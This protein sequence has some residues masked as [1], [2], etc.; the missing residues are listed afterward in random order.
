MIGGGVYS[1]SV[2]AA[3]RIAPAAAVFAA[4]G[5][6][7]IVNGGYFPSSWGWPTLAFLVVVG[8]FAIVADHVRLGRLD[9]VLLV[10]LAAF[11]AWTALSALWASGAELPIQAGELVLV[12]LL[13]VV[14]FL[15][16]GNVSLPLGVLCAVT[17]VAAYALATRLVPDHVGTYK[18][19]VNGYLL[20]VPVGYQN[21]L[22]MLCSL[23]ALVALGLA[24]HAA[25]TDVRIAAA[26]SLVILL[27][28]LYFTFSR[29]AAGA[30]LLGIGVAFAL[31][32]RR[33]R[34]SV[35]L[36]AVLPLPL[37]GAWIGSRS[38]AL[39]HAGASRTAAAHDGHRL[40]LALVV[41]ALLQAGVVVALGAA[42][43][44]IAV[45]PRLRRAYVAALALAAAAIVAA[46]LVRI[47]NPVTFV[48]H[49]TDAFKTDAPTAG[50]NLNHRLVTL[51]SHTRTDYWAAAWHEVRDHPLLGGGAN[52]FRRYWLQYRPAPLGALNA[53][54]LYLETLADLGPIG[55]VL[56][57]VVLAAPLVA[58]ARARRH[59]AVPLAAGA[60]VSYL[61]HAAIDWDWQL[62]AVTLAALAFGSTLVIA[63]RPADASR[64][65]TNA[66]RTITL[67]AAV[68]LVVFVFV[69]Q[70]GNDAVA[71]ADRASA[72]DDDRAALTEAQRARRWL[73]WA[74][75]PWQ[76]LGE[77]QLAE[78]QLV[79][80][81]RSLREAIEKDGSDWSSWL[82]LAL[83]SSG[84]ARAAA[85]AHAAA[86]NPL[87][88]AIKAVRR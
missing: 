66:A 5:W 52:T 2:V 32:S 47:G 61:A 49:A 37:I 82:D 21:G 83:A 80:A 16:I 73:P 7:S 19:A 41:L 53:H 57:L 87:S 17:P 14:V 72:R 22:G 33:L 54:N 69:A 31:D 12:Y 60:Y 13:A 88:S 62:P 3:Q 44:G 81:R 29:G 18:P 63:A 70:L 15:L 30:L 9:V 39:T 67:A 48:G 20:S 24:A 56:L 34:F 74:A 58:T 68:P 71:A 86:L 75:G 46:G 27:P 36:F 23:A 11:V 84:R 6:T 1:R 42:E 78:G 10:A 51:S 50:G 76:R 26:V 85:L 35:A 25:R 8:V 55:L 28:T 77:A 45:T 40:L 59:P 38:R 64:R 4:V 65:M 43:R 79:A